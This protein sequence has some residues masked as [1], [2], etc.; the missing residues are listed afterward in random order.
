MQVMERDLD[1]G[2]GERIE[3]PGDI[4]AAYERA[5]T[6]TGEGK[7]ALIEFITCEEPDMA[8]PARG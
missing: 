4:R 1:L 6:A 2:F 7:P 8:I 3:Q 5:I